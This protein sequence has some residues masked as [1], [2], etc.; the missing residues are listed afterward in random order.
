LGEG[1][2][3]LGGVKWV[4]VERNGGGSGGKGMLG[5]GDVGE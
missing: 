1:K 4:E 2:E 3:T 5:L